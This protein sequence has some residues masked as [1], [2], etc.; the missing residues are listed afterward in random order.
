[1]LIIGVALNVIGSLLMII[2]IFWH[3][4]SRLQNKNKMI[5]FVLFIIISMTTGSLTL[6]WPD[7]RL[8]RLVLGSVSVVFP[9]AFVFFLGGLIMAIAVVQGMN[10]VSV[11]IILFIL[12]SLVA[13]AG[14]V[15]I[16]ATPIPEKKNEE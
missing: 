7:N 1:M 11:V 16:L 15:T 13:F 14:S 5:V 2:T 10:A 9:A 12:S 3:V 6:A 8:V 4:H